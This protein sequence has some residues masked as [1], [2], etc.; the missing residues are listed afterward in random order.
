MQKGVRPYWPILEEKKPFRKTSHRIKIA[1]E[2]LLLDNT[3]I[4]IIG[5]KGD[6]HNKK[7]KARGGGSL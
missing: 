3:Q 1:I 4:M 7:S 5:R 6:L 2:L